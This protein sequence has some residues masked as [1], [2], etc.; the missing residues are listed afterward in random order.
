SAVMVVVVLAGFTVWLTP[1]DVLP[2]KLPSVAYVA[3]T[4]RPPAA[5]NAIVQLPAATLALQLWVPSLTVIV[6][7]GV[8]LPGAFAATVNVKLTAWPTTEG[9]GVWA[10]IVVVVAAAF[11]VCPTP[12]EALPA[13]LAS[14]P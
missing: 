11:T 7:V 14:P 8:P 12:A 6:P 4:I 13:K 5:L 2:A 3:V 1:A 9:S 10:V